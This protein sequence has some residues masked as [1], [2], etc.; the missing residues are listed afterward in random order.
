[1]GEFIMTFLKKYG[2]YFMAIA[3]ISEWVLPLVLA[4]FVPGYLQFTNLISDFGEVES[5]THMAFKVWEVVNG[6][7]F[8]L[9]APAFYAYFK[10]TSKKLSG[11]FTTML[12]IFSLTDCVFTG[13]FDRATSSNTQDITGMIHNYSS[14]IG[15]TALLISMFVLLKLYRMQGKTAIATLLLGAFIISLGIQFLFVYPRIMPDSQFKIPYRGLWQRLNLWLLYMPFLLISV[16]EIFK[17][18]RI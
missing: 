2:F 3:V 6:L 8:L 14:G 1:M 10:N 18:K 4:S 7:L 17:K 11:W 15:D 5:P 16:K 13:L 12:I 9:S